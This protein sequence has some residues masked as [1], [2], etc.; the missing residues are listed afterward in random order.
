MI[1][2]SELDAL[3][4]TPLPEADAGAFSVEMMERIAEHEARPARIAAWVM[5]GLF[6]LLTALTLLFLAPLA[7][8]GA[9]G[10]FTLPAI[11]VALTL[12][13][14]FTVLRSARA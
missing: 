11:L 5:A 9:F 14:S 4:A 2:D 10:M 13:L 3:L 1:T 8:M 12:T 7:H 6:T